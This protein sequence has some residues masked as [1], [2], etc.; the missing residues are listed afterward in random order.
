MKKAVFHTLGCKLNYAETS[1]FMRQF[2]ERGFAVSD[3]LNEHADVCVINTCSVT[4]KADRECRQIVRRALRNSPDAY[5][6]VVGCY[7]QLDPEML[8]SIDGVDLVLGASEKFA[9]FEHADPEFGKETTPRICTSPID[10]ATGFG[11]GY[12]LYGGGRT[13]AFLKVQDGCDYTCSFCTI[14][15][16]R[17]ESRS[18]SIEETVRQAEMLIA[19]GFKEIVLTGVNVGDYGRKVGKS[20]PDLVSN[21]VKLEGLSRLRISSIEPNLITDELFHFWVSSDILV[22]HFHIPMQSGSDDILRS[23]RRRYMSDYYRTLIHNIRRHL[24]HAGIGVDVIVGFPGET[25]KHFEETYRMIVDLPVSYLHVFSYSERHNTPA[26]MFEG[27]ID[28]DSRSRRT[29]MLRILSEKKRRAFMELFIGREVR[30]LF[31]EWTKNGYITGLTPEY[32]RVA[33]PYREGVQNT[34]MTV[35][36][37]SHNGEIAY[38]EIIDRGTINS[39]EKRVRRPDS[40][41]EAVRGG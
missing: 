20:L 26:A 5:I 9:I 10:Q 22:P 25:E 30:V 32:I 41:G 12:S 36:I 37:I 39:T 34:E 13:R 18:Q 15:L 7:A 24:P 31:E 38:G 28:P 29:N 23:M 2:R 8:A 19:E 33:V 3:S 1:S 11:P 4:E 16:A 14:P 21:I 17:G 6:I 40:V 35:E 27:K